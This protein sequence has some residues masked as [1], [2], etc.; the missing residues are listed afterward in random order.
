MVVV[1]VAVVFGAAAVSGASLALHGSAL[2]DSG[3]LGL[4]LG[5]GRLEAGGRAV[6]VHVAHRVHGFVLPGVW[7]G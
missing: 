1:V 3:L 4:G 5:G 6:Q 7:D 2:A